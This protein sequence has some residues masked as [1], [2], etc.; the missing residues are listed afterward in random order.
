M[1]ALALFKFLQAIPQEQLDTMEIS[2]VIIDKTSMVDMTAF[3]NVT[4]SIGEMDELHLEFELKVEE[5]LPMGHN[6]IR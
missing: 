1:N 3:G 6:N 4:A 2:A 5:R